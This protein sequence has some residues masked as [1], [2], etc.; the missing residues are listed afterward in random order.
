MSHLTE[1]PPLNESSLPV[2]LQSKN[3]ITQVYSL[4]ALPFSVLNGGSDTSPRP[5][6]FNGHGEVF[7]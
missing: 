1:D 6:S 3:V 7:G 5:G 4:S 2:E